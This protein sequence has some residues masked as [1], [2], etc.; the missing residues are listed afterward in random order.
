MSLPPQFL[1]ELRNRTPLVPLVARRVRLERAGRDQKGCCPFHNEKSPSFYVYDDHYHCFGCGA[2]GDA[3]SFVMQSEGASFIEAIERLAAEAGLEV[4]KPSP[5]IAEAQKRE[6]ELADV[7]EA[8]AAEYRRRLAAPE[9]EAAR[10]Y[11]AARGLDAPT[12]ARFGLGWSGEGRGALRAALARQGIAES[13]LIEAGLMKEGERGAVD[14]FYNRVM[15]PIRDR[16][17]RMLSFGGRLL[18]DGQPKYLNGPETAL[19][20]KRRTLYGLDSAR[21]AIRTGAALIVVEGYMDVIALAA[22]GFAGAVAP[23]GTA[24]T[25]SHLEELW[26]LSPRP[27]LCLDG[28]AAGRRAALRTIELALK[29]LTPE[30]GLAVLAL[31]PGDDPDSFVRRE[32][33]SAFAARLAAIPSLADTLYDLLAEAADQSTPEGR[34]ALRARLEALARL[35]DDRA[36]AGEYRA[37]LLDRFFAARRDRASAARPGGSAAFRPGFSR[38]GFSRSGFSRP[39]FANPP[40]L[41]LPRPPID[42]AIAHRR[43]ARLLTG[44][45]IA[46]PDLLPMLEEAF[47]LLALPEECAR[48]RAAMAAWL[49]T[50]E[51]LDS[52]HLLNHLTQSGLGEEAALVLGGIPR[53]GTGTDTS[54]TGADALQSLWYGLYGL[55]NLDWLRQQ[56][57]EQRLRFEQDPTPENNTRLRALVEARYRAERGEADLDA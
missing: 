16:K 51:T 43:R 17:G 42:T 37:A 13:R 15:F 19:F 46:H 23:L 27:I 3:I 36:L 20:S 30:R 39:G 2:H 49:A 32:G 56:C 26:R 5:A 18:G 1:D 54:A 48:L 40:P 45:L 8:A 11:L 25:D 34:A 47:G 52:E 41:N 57:E 29:Q 33:A 44:L 14:Y 55:M 9:G 12:I 24:L 6:A 38:P 10:A 28:D 31:P 21:P 50:A 4:P 53:P 35:I 22:A 7:L